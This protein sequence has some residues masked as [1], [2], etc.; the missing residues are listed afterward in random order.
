MSELAIIASAQ[1]VL[2]AALVILVF[3]GAFLVEGAASN[4]KVGAVRGKRVVRHC[5]EVQQIISFHEFNSF[6]ALILY[7]FT[8]FVK[9]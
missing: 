8:N 7:Y 6:F 5:S 4:S 9:N 1:K 3:A 2:I